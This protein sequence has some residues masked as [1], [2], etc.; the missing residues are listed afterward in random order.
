MPSHRGIEEWPRK[1]ALRLRDPRLR[2]FTQPRATLLVVSAHAGGVSSRLRRCSAASVSA[3]TDASVHPILPYPSSAC[4][5][6]PDSLIS[7]A[8]SDRLTATSRD[9]EE[10]VRRIREQQDDERRKKLEEL[11]EHVSQERKKERVGKKGEGKGAKINEENW[12]SQYS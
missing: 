8:G 6:I 5:H 12:E 2:E 7:I 4:R 10:R 3:P 11:K 9:R 1:F